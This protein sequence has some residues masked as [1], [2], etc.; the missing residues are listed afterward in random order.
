MTLEGTGLRAKEAFTRLSPK[1][2]IIV[3]VAAFVVGCIL[4]AVSGMVAYRV[5][6]SRYNKRE[7]AR[8]KQVQEALAAADAAN[9]RAEAKEAQAELLKQQMDAKAKVTTADRVK[10]EQES[11]RNEEKIKSA[12]EHD[13]AF[14][15]SDLSDCE[16][17]R[18][19]CSRL[20]AVAV[21][22]PALAKYACAADACAEQ[23]P[24]D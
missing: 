18:D 14:I 5:S 6:Y 15:N 21:S 2:K 20:D 24:P 7:A 17:C 4:V 9:R 22:N 16:R 3:F 1:G 8:M 11:E 13:Q 19:V 10:L 12:Y 23:C